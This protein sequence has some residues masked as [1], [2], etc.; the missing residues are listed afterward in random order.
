M[1]NFTEIGQ[2]QAY[3]LENKWLAVQSLILF[4]EEDNPEDML[5]EVLFRFN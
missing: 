3:F 1:P 4:A 2:I 5:R